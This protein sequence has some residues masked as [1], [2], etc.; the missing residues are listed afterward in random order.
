[1]STGSETVVVFGPGLMGGSLLLG[2]R[3]CAPQVRLGAWARRPD[4]LDHLVAAGVADF[5]TTDAR[6]AA[7]QATILV[8]C[9]PVAGLEALARQI[10]PEVRADAVVTDVG[11]VKAAIVAPLEEVFSAHCNFV[12]SHPMCGSEQAGFAAARA[13]LYERAICV[14]TP[15]EHSRSGAVGRVGNLWQSVGGRVVEMSPA[16]HDRAAGAASHLPHAT[17]AA[18]V[19]LVASAGPEARMLCA[20]GFSDTT[21]IASGSPALW[22]GILEMNRDEVVRALDELCA[23]LQGLR[24]DL[25]RHDGPA[26]EAF[27][28]SARRQ[29]AEIVQPGRP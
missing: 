23:I 20:G 19:R 14:V 5:V 18:V 16:A 28:E 24:E 29:R 3:K 22:T 6:E 17:A 27:L 4:A 15:T 9:L 25:R 13:D 1:M 2:L 21:R 7:R 12:G 26:V 10:A 11:S 8:L